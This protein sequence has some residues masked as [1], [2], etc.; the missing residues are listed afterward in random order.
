MLK[1][2][3]CEEDF[4]STDKKPLVLTC[5]HTFCKQT[6]MEMFFKKQNDAKQCP[7]KCIDK[8]VYNNIDEVGVNY[9]VLNMVE[10]SGAQEKCSVHPTTLCDM[11]CSNCDKRICSKCLKEHKNHNFEDFE[12]YV[13]QCS[14]RKKD[15][16]AFIKNHLVL[17]DQRKEEIQLDHFI[18]M[19]ELEQELD[20]ALE[21]LK[22]AK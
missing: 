2:S 15:A 16:L 7:L 14:D 13:K 8:L 11:Y 3:I 6:V 17:S 9:F 12:D 18:A 21:I 20:K 1:C 10:Q 4:N 22:A 19:I 5:G